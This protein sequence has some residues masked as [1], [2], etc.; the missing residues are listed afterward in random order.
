MQQLFNDYM[1]RLT[2]VYSGILEDIDIYT[3]LMTGQRAS[4]NS[5]PLETVL[6]FD[7]EVPKLLGDYPQF[8]YLTKHIFKTEDMFDSVKRR[9]AISPELF[10]QYERGKNI[11]TPVLLAELSRIS[12]REECDFLLNYLE[13]NDLKEVCLLRSCRP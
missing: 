9:M 3:E 8:S 11:L 12:K 10:P 7:K 1:S 4:K 2:N 6:K 5:V 13:K